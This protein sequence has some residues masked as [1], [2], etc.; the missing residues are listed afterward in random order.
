MTGI[1]EETREYAC[2]STVPESSTHFNPFLVLPRF[3][4]GGT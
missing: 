4:L 1:I 3:I 2:S